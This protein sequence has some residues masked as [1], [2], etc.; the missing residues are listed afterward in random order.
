MLVNPITDAITDFVSKLDAQ[1]AVH[2][3]EIQQLKCK[4]ACMDE[5]R[6]NLAE[7]YQGDIAARRTEISPGRAKLMDD[8]D[9][10][11]I[12]LFLQFLDRC[13]EE[14]SKANIQKVF[15]KLNHYIYNKKRRL[16]NS[17]PEFK[18]DLDDWVAR[19]GYWTNALPQREGHVD[20][21]NFPLMVG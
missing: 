1:I 2:E 16:W 14:P 15:P 10:T 7:Q 18:Q 6:R 12:N 17:I 11:K 13:G 9:V 20:D 5:F 21:L 4:K 8:K 3:Q 19:R